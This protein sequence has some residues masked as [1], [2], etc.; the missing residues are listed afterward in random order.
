MPAA[1]LPVGLALLLVV[2]LLAHP[3]AQGADQRQPTFRSRVTLVPIDVRVLDARGRPVTDLR[4]EDFSVREDDEPQAIEYFSFTTLTPAA[5][6]DGPPSLRRPLDASP[7]AAPTRRTFLFVLGRGRQVGPG[8]NVRAGIDFIRERLLPQDQVAILAWN[9]TTRFTTD[10]EAAARTLESY[11][12][13]HELIEARLDHHYHGLAMAMADPEIPPAIQRLVDE[14]FEQ[15]G[16]LPA[17]HMPPGDVTDRASYDEEI[18]RN[19]AAV[20]ADADDLRSGLMRNSPTM[21]DVE[22]LFAGITYMRY[23]EGEKHLIF[24]TPQGLALQR[25][26]NSATIARLASDARVALEMIHT[27]GM[28]GPPPSNTRVSFNLPTAGM[29]FNMRWR[30]ENSRHMS[31]I[32]GGETAGFKYGQQTFARLDASTRAQYLL[33]YAPTN[34]T[35]DGRYRRVRVTV[36]RP[37]VRVLARQGYYARPQETPPDRRQ[38]MTYSRI[39]A[40]LQYPLPIRDIRVA[41]E[42]P[43]VIDGAVVATARIEPGGLR[44]DRDGEHQVAALDAFFSAGDDRDTLVGEV[45]QRLELRLLPQEHDRVVREGLTFT[46]RVP[47]RAPPARLKVVLY[48]YE[49]DVI[50]SATAEIKR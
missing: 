33:G 49:R 2:V 11:W 23:L 46:V 44:F 26:E 15:P 18:A 10:H 13:R 14:V 38:F 25:K 12:Q 32:S 47:V 39:V 29:V 7:L 40:A 4:R 19:A 34:G 28:I 50:G 42:T 22:N 35:W 43:A 48:D 5:P 24:L 16:V 8:R 30:L 6:P 3:A 27:H 17:R 1:R 20:L 45:S 36:R 21:R 37:G 41:L 9:R 31:E